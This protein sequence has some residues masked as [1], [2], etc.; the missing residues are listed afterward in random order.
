[1]SDIDLL[2]EI[3]KPTE[4]KSPAGLTLPD[5]NESDFVEAPYIP[6]NPAITDTPAATTQTQLPPGT[7]QPNLPGN[8]VPGLQ[9][10]A[11]KVPVFDPDFSSEI[12]IDT[13]DTMQHGL[14]LALNNRKQKNMRFKNRDEYRE[15]ISLSYLTDA[16]LQKLENYEEKKILVEKLKTFQSTMEKVND[17]ISFLPDEKMRLKK[18]IYQLVKQ[19]NFDIPPGLALMLVA[20]DII[21]NRVIDL[22]YD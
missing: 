13:I 22:I 2:S 16:E 21:S 7:T 8:P 1:M 19:N 6:N 4:Y 14:F 12:V 9:P 3:K 18:P 11:P 10:E 20:T 17:K 5:V 15:A